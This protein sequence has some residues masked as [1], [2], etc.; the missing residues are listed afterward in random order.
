MAKDYVIDGEVKLLYTIGELAR[1]IDKQP[2]T[3]RKWEEKG[4]IPPA[5]Y[6]DGSN[7]RLY[8]AEQI[9]GLRELTKQ[10]IKQ[11]TKT[12]D[13]FINGAKALFL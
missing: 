5:K 12:P 9:S 3:I 2:V 1:A 6:R 8:S 4:V 11:G 7:R 10:H 13:E